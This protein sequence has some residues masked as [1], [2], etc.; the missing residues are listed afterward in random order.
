MPDVDGGLR[1]QFI[2]DALWQL[3]VEILTLRRWF[4]PTVADGGTRKHNTVTPWFKAPGPKDKLIPNAI[5][6][7]IGMRRTEDAEVG[8]NSELVRLPFTFDIYGESDSIG[9]RLAGDLRDGLAGRLPS[10][11]RREPVLD[12][13][14]YN[15][16][17]T[18]PLLFQCSIEDVTTD[19]AFGFV[20]H[21]QFW[22]TV[23]GEL[24]DQP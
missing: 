7:Y 21:R 5:G 8:S 3:A 24:E 12:V 19:Q 4:E 22:F 17:A 2:K 6:L 20:D 16:S 14:D 9:R 23:E 18:P 1:D 10:I 15:Y 11:G 13:Y